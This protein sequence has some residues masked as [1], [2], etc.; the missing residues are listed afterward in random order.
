MKKP[1][2]PVCSSEDLEDDMVTVY[3]MW[4]E[5]YGTEEVKRCLRCGETFR[6]DEKHEEDSNQGEVEL[7]RSGSTR[8]VDDLS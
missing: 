1:R 7:N 6:R 2:C 5:L 3:G 4:G 8:R